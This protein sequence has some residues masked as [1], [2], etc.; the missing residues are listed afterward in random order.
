MRVCES[1]LTL[2]SHFLG[3]VIFCFETCRA[4]VF[5]L[6]GSLDSHLEG[7]GKQNCFEYGVKFIYFKVSSTWRKRTNSIVFF[8]RFNLK[9]YV[10]AGNEESSRVCAV[11]SCVG[12]VYK[13]S[14]VYNT[15]ILYTA[16]V[17]QNKHTA[18]CKLQTSHYALHTAN[19]ILHNSHWNCTCTR[20]LHTLK[21]KI[22][23]Y[24]LPLERS[25]SK[26]I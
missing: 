4:A 15:Y 20:H 21:K 9:F 19:C 1:L 17:P 16:G 2:W 24:S 10:L 12:L 25:T 11:P 7:M 18:H 3:H 6:I 26:P 23:E 14:H 13:A 5:G 8:F 22:T